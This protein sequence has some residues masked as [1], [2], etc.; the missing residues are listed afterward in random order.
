MR[1][2]PVSRLWSWLLVL[3]LSVVPGAAWAQAYFVAQ[4]SGNQENPPIAG[5][6]SG[7]AAFTLIGSDLYYSLT[8]QGLT[9]PITA[10]HIHAGARGVNGG[11]VFNLGGDFIDPPSGVGSTASG[12]ISG[13]S[14][15]QVTALLSGDYYVNVHTAANPGGEV[16]GQLDLAAGTHLTADLS[17]SDENPPVAGAGRG[18]AALTLTD[19]GL[20]VDLTVTGLTG[21]I[22]RRTST[23]AMSA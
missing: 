5:S 8:V 18:T 1:V 20:M 4:L 9:G 15:T 10:A 12:H 2:S 19:E 22:L 17:G 21:R 16:R 6:G 11:V 7:T 3:L 14:S 23:V 13:M